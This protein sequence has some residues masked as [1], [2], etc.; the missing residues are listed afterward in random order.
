MSERLVSGAL[1]FS[2]PGKVILHG[3]HSVVYG[4]RGVALSLDLRTTLRLV[5]AS[6][7]VTLDLPDVKIREHWT[8]AQLW[9]LYK[10]LGLSSLEDSSVHNDDCEDSAAVA[11]NIR[12][13][14][15]A[16][17]LIMKDFLK[18]KRD[19]YCQRTKALLSFLHLYTSLLP[20]PQGF[21]L[22]VSSKIPTGAGLGSSAAYATCLTGALLVLSG[23]VSAGA[24]TEHADACARQRA[25]SLVNLWTYTSEAIMHGKPSGIDNTTCSYG[26]VISF[27]SGQIGLEGDAG[28]QVLLIDTQIPRSTEALV[29]SVRD[30]RERMPE[31]VEPI[32]ESMDAIAEKGLSILRKL[33]KLNAETTKDA[34]EEVSNEAAVM[35]MSLH[36]ELSSL[37]DVNHRLLGALGVSHPALERVADIAQEHGLSAKLTGAGGGGFAV[38][39]LPPGR[40]A[41]AY[42]ACLAALRDAGCRVWTVELGVAGLTCRQV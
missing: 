21:T 7:S 28:L 32:L 34:F 33:T 42:A 16:N 39:P 35:Q 3:E 29:K 38:A 19:S 41:A 20:R 23:R 1:V 24:F 17:A 22:R 25:L 36:R 14:S 31:V 5:P 9:S 2:A 10:L 30:K 40:K 26:G 12:E 18:I 15:S 11:A 13:L 37:V 8:V 4:K 27:K 6:D